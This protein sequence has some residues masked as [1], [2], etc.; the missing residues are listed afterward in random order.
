MINFRFV[1]SQFKNVKIPLILFFIILCI[2]I[3]PILTQDYLAP[4]MTFIGEEHGVSGLGGL[5]GMT[6]LNFVFFWYS[7]VNIN[8]FF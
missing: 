2:L 8:F 4:T 3:V 6:Y 5:G 7:G 1:K